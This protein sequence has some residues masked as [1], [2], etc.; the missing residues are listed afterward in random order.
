[1]RGEWRQIGGEGEWK[2]TN[3]VVGL[4]GYIY[5]SHSNGKVFAISPATGQWSQLGSSSGWSTR[6]MFALGNMVCLV[7]HSGT[8]WALDPNSGGHQQIGKDGE[9][10]N[11]DCG[12]FSNDTI[13]CHSKQGTLWAFS[14]QMGWQQIGNN[15]NWKSRFI[16]ASEGLVTV[17]E[18]NSIYRVDMRSGDHQSL[19]R[20]QDRALAGVGL[21]G[22]VYSCF[23][24]GALWDLEIQTGR[25]SQV[26]TAN[27]WQS[28]ALL[29]NGNDIVTLER[30]GTL[31]EVYVG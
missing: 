13:Y 24:D 4:N 17:E 29:A 2:G 8:M 27:T 30:R 16:F 22:H 25:W 18:D 5:A 28:Q 1:M 9:W 10:A 7:E 6:L 19:G 23:D 31:F 20:M 21:F 12:D 11:I 14:G 26:G 3:A 15:A